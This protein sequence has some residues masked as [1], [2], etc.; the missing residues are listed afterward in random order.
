[1]LCSTA[2]LENSCTGMQADVDDGNSGRYVKQLYLHGDA[3][4]LTGQ[5]RQTE[6]HLVLKYS[7]SSSH[8]LP[9]CNLYC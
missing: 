5:T 3:C 4:D 6:V 9:S 8:R 1:M 7:I 2:T